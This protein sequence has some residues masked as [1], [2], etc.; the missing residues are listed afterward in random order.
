[1]IKKITS[2]ENNTLK[3]IKKLQKKSERI[4]SGLFVAEGKRIVE[5][6]INAKAVEFI[7]T[8]DESADFANTYLVNH[9]LYE[10]ISDTK[11]PQGIMAVCKIPEIST[12]VFDGH[13]VVCDG[14]KDPGNLGT[15]IRTAECAGFGAVLLIND[16]VDAYNPKTVRST[17]GSIFRIPVFEFT[18]D[19]LKKLDDYTLAVTMLDGAVDIFKAEFGEKVALVIGSEAN[20]VSDE[21]KKLAQLPV[22][23]PMCGEAESINAAVAAGIAM[24]AI[25]NATEK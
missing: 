11:S 1:M 22:K 24:Y 6:A 2:A 23:I 12:N 25:K 20:G 16:C 19:D 4:K 18:V 3:Q 21:I 13:I 17:M 7:V 9:S 5:D 14:I 8:C 10:K 15:V